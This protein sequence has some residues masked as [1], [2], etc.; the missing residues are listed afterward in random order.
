MKYAL[1]ILVLLS[2]A[3]EA[4][5]EMHR[6]KL[7]LDASMD[8]DMGRVRAERERFKI[9]AKKIGSARPWDGEDIG[10]VSTKPVDPK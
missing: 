6:S 8:H 9:Q 4:A 7:L 5:A 2:G 3:S 10:L 1:T